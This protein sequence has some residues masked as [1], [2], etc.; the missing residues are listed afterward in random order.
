[1]FSTTSHIWPYPALLYKR[2]LWAA[3][4][5]FFFLPDIPMTFIGEYEGHAFRTKTTNIFTK[6]TLKNDILDESICEA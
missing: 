1:M 2:G 6:I 4:D 3:V 5:L